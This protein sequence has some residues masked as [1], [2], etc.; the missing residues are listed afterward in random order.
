MRREIRIL[1]TAIVVTVAAGLGACVAPQTETAGAQIAPAPA[2]TATPTPVLTPP[3]TPANEGAFSIPG[4]QPSVATASNIALPNAIPD[5]T[6]IVINAPAYRMDIFDDGALVKS[7]LIGI[8]YPEFPLP[9]GM[10][11]ADAIIFNPTWTPPDEPWVESPRSKV[12][13]G[14]KVAAGSKLNPHM[15]RKLEVSDLLTKAVERNLVRH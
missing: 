1:M 15:A 3:P 9:T 14:Q 2:M 12:K 5:D 10:R 11:M 4:A 6:R 8:G 7:Y 13:V